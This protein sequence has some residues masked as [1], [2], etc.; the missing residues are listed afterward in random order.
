MIDGTLVTDVRDDGAATRHT[1]P[2]FSAQA[3]PDHVQVVVGQAPRHLRGARR[4]V[5]G[6]PRGA[7][8]TERHVD[9]RLG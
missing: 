4:G 3:F 1:A 7:G 6:P 8:V 5:E 2:L 9:A